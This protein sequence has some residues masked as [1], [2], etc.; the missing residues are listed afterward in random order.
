M[1]T[2]DDD[3]LRVDNEKY[4]LATAKRRVHRLRCTLS[5]SK[6]TYFSTY[7][8]RPE[9][10]NMERFGS[11][12][13]GLK[14]VA[15]TCPDIACRATNFTLEEYADNGR[16]FLSYWERK[17]SGAICIL[18][19]YILHTVQATTQGKVSF[20]K[21]LSAYTDA[22]FAN[23]TN[24]SSQLGFIIMLT[25]QHGDCQPLCWSSYTWNESHDQYWVL[26]RWHWAMDLKM[27]LS[28]AC[29]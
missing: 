11:L 8:N 20:C 9:N 17:G 21:N 7:W 10:H 4:V 15:N 2:R 3:A 24:N 5:E 19:I 26:K 27:H 12:H 14:W 23:N 6:W 13:V 16:I 18:F 22:S 1:M 28:S 25:D 29:W